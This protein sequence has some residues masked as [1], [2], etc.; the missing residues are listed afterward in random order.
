MIVGLHDVGVLCALGV[1]PRAVREAMARG[2]TAGM[3]HSVGRAPGRDLVVGDLTAPLPALP[4]SLHRFD[5]RNNRLA[6][7]ALEQLRGTLDPLLARTPAHR[8]GVAI[9]TSTS[10]IAEG[11]EAVRA[12]VAG[13][14]VP[15]TFDYRQQEPAS[16]GEFVATTLGATGP[17]VTVSTACTSSAR[18]MITA[19]RWL[20][21]D[22]C[23]VVIAGGVD[24]MC[25]LTIRG[26]ISIDAVSRGACRPFAADR[27]G[28]NLGEGAALFV[29]TRDRAPVNL[30][31]AG[32]SSDAYH[33][34][35]PDPSGAGAVSAMRAAL[36]DAGLDADAIDYV[37][38]HGTATRHN[39]A[40]EARA[41]AELFPNGVP[42]SSTKPLTGHTLGA[43]AA[44]EAA[45][46]WLSLTDEARRLPPQVSSEPRDPELPA[47]ALAQVGDVARAA[48]RLTFMSNSF[49]FGGNNA[50]LVFGGGA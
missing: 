41:V 7:A 19:R 38:L 43:A 35:S 40:M 28:I 18:A 12:W 39:D 14:A 32:S 16:T 45:L 37:N 2:S 44:V 46:C 29:M 17:V 20:A 11:G 27:D 23:D 50:S 26:F 48:G 5:S 36:A 31:G 25:D 10:G 30:L 49:A 22:L 6:L 3:G 34:S 15:S 4:D 13:P 1:G 24:T 47:L 42:C 8:I 21:L 9:G 33:M